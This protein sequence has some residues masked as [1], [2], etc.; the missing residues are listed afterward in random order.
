[1]AALPIGKNHHSRLAL[2]KYRGYLEPILP[3]VL[4]ASVR[5]IEGAAPAYLENGGGGIGLASAISGAAAR[6][7]FALRQIED[8]GAMASLRH[9]EQRAAAGLLHIVAV[10]GDGQNIERDAHFFLSTRKCARSLRV[11]ARAPNESSAEQPAAIN[12]SACCNDAST[13]NNAGS[14]A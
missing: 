4:D 14:V 13:P 2:A 11:C 8:A 6:A 7:H 9:L 1:M 5:N 3:G 12:E 10:R